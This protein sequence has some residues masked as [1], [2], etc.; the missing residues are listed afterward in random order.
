MLELRKAWQ[1]ENA[2]VRHVQITSRLLAVEGIV[3]IKETK[4]NGSKDNLTLSASYIP[5]LGSVSEG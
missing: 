5:V 4:I 1:K 2:I 3:D